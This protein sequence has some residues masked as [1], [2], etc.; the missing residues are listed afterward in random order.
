MGGGTLRRSQHS[1]VPE[2]NLLSMLDAVSGSLGKFQKFFVQTYPGQNRPKFE[3]SR[4]R[5]RETSKPIILLL[6][7]LSSFGTF[8]VPANLWDTFIDYACW[9]EPAILR[10]LAGLTREWGI[11]DYEKL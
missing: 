5:V 6:D 4:T 9:V 1:G 7:F 8:R 2:I 3:C 10:E 11:A